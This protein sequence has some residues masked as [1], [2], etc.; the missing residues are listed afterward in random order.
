MI[1]TIDRLLIN[2]DPEGEAAKRLRRYREQAE[3][4][5]MI[6]PGA[7]RWI[8]GLIALNDNLEC[9]R[10]DRAGRCLAQQGATCAHHDRYRSCALYSQ[11]L[12][13]TRR[14]HDPD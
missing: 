3:R 13:S 5:V 8:N 4:R 1:E 12:E 9:G 11:Q 7:L 14:S 10:M 2:A 6:G